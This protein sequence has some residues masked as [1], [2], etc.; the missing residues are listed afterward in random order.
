[1]TVMIVTTHPVKK[2]KFRPIVK[3][4]LPL[5]KSKKQAQVPKDNQKLPI[6]E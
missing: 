4:S 1:M 6:L 2:K 5:S 3:K